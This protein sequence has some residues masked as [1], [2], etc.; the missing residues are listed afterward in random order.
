MTIK[1]KICGLTTKEAVISAVENGA[2]YVGFVFFPL[3]PRNMRLD[4]LP[5]LL[6]LVPKDV[7]KVGVFVN[8][9][10]DELERTFKIFKPDYIQLHGDEDTKRIYDLHIKYA[11]PVIKAIAVRSSDDIAKGQSFSND[12]D[13]LLF[14]AKVPSSPLPGGNGLSFDWTLLRERKFMVPWF[15][16]GGINIGNVEEALDISG[17]KKVDISSSLESEPGIKDPE[18]IRIFLK[19]VKNYE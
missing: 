7:K 8:P 19:K 12:A 10:D 14:D 17:A 6:D 9:S 3:S 1:V 4:K 2:D 16:S 15:L 13:M 11:I 18:L 5:E